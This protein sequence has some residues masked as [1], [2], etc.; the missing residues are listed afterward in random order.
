MLIS[1]CGRKPKVSLRAHCRDTFCMAPS[2]SYCALRRLT[3]HRRSIPIPSLRSP[4]ISPSH[5][6][7]RTQRAPSSPSLVR[8]AVSFYWSTRNCDP[9]YCKSILRP[10]STESLPHTLTLRSKR[11]SSHRDSGS[12]PWT[13]ESM[14]RA[15]GAV[16]VA[17]A[18]N[19]GKI[20]EAMSAWEVTMPARRPPPLL[21]GFKSEL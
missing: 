6:P 8:I 16:F 5:N 11:L 14:Q 7:C 19:E 17:R 10:R 9:Q 12:E 4:F 21:V 18:G 3:K 15:Y 2:C 13:Q 1:R 20:L